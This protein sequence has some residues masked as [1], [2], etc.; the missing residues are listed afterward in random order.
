MGGSAQTSE[1]AASTEQHLHADESRQVALETESGF[2]RSDT[3]E[4]SSTGSRARAGRKGGLRNLEAL[5][6]SPHG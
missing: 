1:T 6:F 5:P 2:S 3:G 4:E